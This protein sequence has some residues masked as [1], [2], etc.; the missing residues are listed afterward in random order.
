MTAA[1]H[2]KRECPQSFDTV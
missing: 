1:H 2:Q